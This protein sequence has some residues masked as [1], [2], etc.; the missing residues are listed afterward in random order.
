MAETRL[1]YSS[2]YDAPV[3]IHPLIRLREPLDATV[4]FGEKR[5]VF[6]K[7]NL[8]VDHVTDSD[9]WGEQIAF[10]VWSRRFP[11]FEAR[12]LVH[13]GFHRVAWS[14]PVLMCKSFNEKLLEKLWGLI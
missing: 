1:Y 8:A 12:P 3:K 13:N 14:L 9:R 4:C 5:I 2:N 10:N 6:E 11:R 7:A